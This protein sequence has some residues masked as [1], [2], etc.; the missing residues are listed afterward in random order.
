LLPIFWSRTQILKYDTIKKH[1]L[2]PIYWSTKSNN[3]SNKILFPL[4]FSFKDTNHQSFTLF[5]LLSM[6]HSTD[7]TKKYFMLTPL[8][9][10]FKSPD[11]T[12]AYFFPIFDISK[13][14]QETKSSFLLFLYNKTKR[15]NYAEVSVLWPIC[16]KVKFDNYRYLRIAPIVWYEK[17]DSSSMFSIQP[18]NYCYKSNTKKTYI[19]GW[20]LYKYENIMGISTANNILWKAYTTEKFTNGDFETRFLHLIYANI[21]KNGEREISILPIYHKINYK[22]GDM[23]KSVFF[24]FYNHFTQYIPEI[25]ES[26]E[27]ERFFWF[28]RLRSNYEKLKGEGKAKYLRRK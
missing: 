28:L 5:P 9:G 16:K 3:E 7:D 19:L 24:G 2:F 18:I 8:S 6:G 25:K 10:Y 21:K 17:T 11:K 20:F 1:T 12:N 13:S 15:Q 14:K 4:L 22:N 27:E 26:Y 23:L